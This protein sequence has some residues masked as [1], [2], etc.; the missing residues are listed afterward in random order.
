MSES[1]DELDFTANIMAD[2][3][4]A[5]GLTKECQEMLTDIFEG[6]VGMPDRV[7]VFE[8]FIK[9]LDDRELQYK[10]DDFVGDGV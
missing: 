10:I 8:L 4:E 1:Y 9:E 6:T 5:K 3:Y 7:R 2:I